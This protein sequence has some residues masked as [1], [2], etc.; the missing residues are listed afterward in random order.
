MSTLQVQAAPAAAIVVYC[1]LTS[2]GVCVY[3][4]LCAIASAV[5]LPCPTAVNNITSAVYHLRGVCEAR[6][7]LNMNF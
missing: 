1:E 3:L 7:T 2:V 5:D 4:W 6:L